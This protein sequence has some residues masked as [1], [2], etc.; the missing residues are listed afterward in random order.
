M[1][2]LA[3]ILISGLLMGAPIALGFDVSAPPTNLTGWLVF[4]ISLCGAIGLMNAFFVR[5]ILK[6][7]IQNELKTLPTRIEFEAHDKKDT[8]FQTRVESFMEDRGPHLKE[9]Y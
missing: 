7:A 4:V 9:R 1:Y 6:P 3:G 2:F 8:D 5:F